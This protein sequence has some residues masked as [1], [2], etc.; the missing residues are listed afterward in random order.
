MQCLLPLLWGKQHAVMA[1]ALSNALAMSHCTDI[2]MD[3][4]GWGLLS[5]RKHLGWLGLS[6]VILR[7]HS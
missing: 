6:L 4:L 1:M 7:L 5:W 3:L 2:A